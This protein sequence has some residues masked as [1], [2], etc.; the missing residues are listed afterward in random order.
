ARL[1]HARAAALLRQRRANDYRAEFEACHPEARDGAAELAVAG[2]D[3]PIYYQYPMT[4]LILAR[5]RLTVV[6][7]KPLADALREQMPS[8]TVQTV[9]LG[10]G[11]PAT[12]DD[13]GARIRAKYGIPADAIVFGC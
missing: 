12:R 3:S 9:A 8:A 10:H 2:F 5:S 13:D 7:T 11:T 1:H 4:R 6:H